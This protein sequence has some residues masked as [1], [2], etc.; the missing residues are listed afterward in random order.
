MKV[1]SPATLLITLCLFSANVQANYT[2]VWSDE[3]NY[4]GLPDSTNWGYDVGG[5]GW[6]NEERQYYTLNRLENARVGDGVLTIEARKEFWGTSQYTSARLVSRGKGDWTYGRFEIRAKLPFGRGTWPALWLLPTD[7]AYGAW[8]SS[9]EIDIMEHVGYDMD[10]VH[11]TIHTLSYNSLNG[12]QISSSIHVDNVDTTFHEYALEWRPNRIDAFIDGQ[13]YFTFSNEGAGYSVWPFNKRFH[14]IMN[15][16]VGGIHGAVQGVDDSIFPQTMAVDYVR[17]YS[18]DDYNYSPSQSIPARI[19]AESFSDQFGIRLEETL[20][21][22]GGVNAGY[23]GHNDWMEYNLDVPTTGIYSIDL[24]GASPTGRAKVVI[25]AND[26]QLKS[27]AV[28]ATYGW[29][30]WA[31]MRIGEIFL[32]KGENTLRVTIDSP[33]QDDLNINWLDIQLVQADPNAGLGVFE[34]YP[35]TGDW[36][37]S[38]NY[39]GWVNVAHY[40]WVY[41]DRISKYVY[42]D[43]QWMYVPR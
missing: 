37:D 8:P 30:T 40:P 1:P 24:R 19:E 42:M 10:N 7:W 28:T 2:L 5:N 31:T 35:M 26:Q 38:G 43:G 9:G 11:G 4:T 16:A 25:D 6:G 27:G 32:P 34:D 15:I 13:I 22:G 29:Q 12:N 23:L 39:L 14:L 36:V 20:D 33:I 41:V 17:V 18:I 21:A 3:F